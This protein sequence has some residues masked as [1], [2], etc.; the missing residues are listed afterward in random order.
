[1]LSTWRWFTPSVAV[2]NNASYGYAISYPREWYLFNR[3]PEGISISQSDPGNMIDTDLVE[4]S[5]VVTIDVH[6]NPNDLFL[7]DWVAA[8]D[9]SVDSMSEV[10]LGSLRGLR[11][12]RSGPTPEI[13]T[14]QGLFKG[15]LGRVY[16]ITCLYPVDRQWSYRPIANA[17]I[18]SFSF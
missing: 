15:P 6:E 9:W 4:K 2:Y 5:M 14:M 8:Q 16:S 12:T 7:I 11:V 17:I 1:M 18:Y 3:R 13:Q 10:P